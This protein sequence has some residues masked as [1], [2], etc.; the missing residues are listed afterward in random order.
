MITENEAQMEEG[1][2]K[3]IEDT[4]AEGTSF[5]LKNYGPESYKKVVTI[6]QEIQRFMSQ[7]EY[8][9]VLI[10]AGSLLEIGIRFLIIKPLAIGALYHEEWANIIA[11]KIGTGMSKNDRDILPKV[12]NTIDIDITNIG[13]KSVNFNQK[14]NSVFG[15]RNDIIHNFEN[16][17]KHDA[18]TAIECSNL[19]LD[20]ILPYI[21]KKY[22][23]DTSDT[24]RW[25]IIY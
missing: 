18:E 21:F 3:V 7:R 10:L 1:F 14:L 19:L 17:S 9:V 16:A 23:I 22:Q 6:R 4:I 15:K 20:H 24:Q 8:R 5:Y 12:L 25:E 13:P 2:L 11:T